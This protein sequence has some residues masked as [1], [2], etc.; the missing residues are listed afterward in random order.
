MI[1]MF[2]KKSYNSLLKYHLMLF[3]NGSGDWITSYYWARPSCI[4][5]HTST[6]MPFPSQ[7]FPKYH[8]LYFPNLGNILFPIDK[9]SIGEYEV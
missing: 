3:E 4:L 9:Q 7:E 6:S 8:Q 1:L 2:V 5:F